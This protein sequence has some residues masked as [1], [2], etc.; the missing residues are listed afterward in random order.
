MCTIYITLFF[1]LRRSDTIELGTSRSKVNSSWTSSLKKLTGCER[2]KSQDTK[3]D[4]PPWEQLELDF[5]GVVLLP[6]APVKMAA[7]RKSS[8]ASVM[9]II[10][11]SPGRMIGALKH[12]APD[13]GPSGQGPPVFGGALTS[14][15][16]TTVAATNEWQVPTLFLT[17]KGSGDPVSAISNKE[18]VREETLGDFLKLDKAIFV[19]TQIVQEL[20]SSGAIVESASAYF[21]HQASLLMFWF[22]VAYLFTL[23]PSLVRL[24]TEIA[25]GRE[26]RTLRLIA[27]LATI[28]LGLQDVFIFGVV[29][30]TIKRRVRKELPNHL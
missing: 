7:E 4:L 1:F 24:F 3:S 10:T 22:P 13:T 30:W 26:H 18:A 14:R 16:T 21:N 27:N 8:V 23:T 25:T 11:R 28:S 12:N 20:A 2:K 6:P 17:D 29:E 9:S 5:S 15:T 19:P